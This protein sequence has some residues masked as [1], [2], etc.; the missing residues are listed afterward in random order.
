MLHLGSMD[1]KDYSGKLGE[2]LERG[3]K[4][5]PKFHKFV[6]EAI[7]KRD[8]RKEKAFARTKETLR[9]LLP[10]AEETRFETLLRK[11]RSRRGAAG[12]K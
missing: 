7:A 12:G 9:L 4:D 10:E 11:P 6:A 2:L 5:T 1:L 3:A 8:A